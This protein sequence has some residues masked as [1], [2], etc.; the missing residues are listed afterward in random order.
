M[1]KIRRNL[2]KLI[3]CMMA[4]LMVF[5]GLAI[6]PADAASP[7]VVA[8]G[9]MKDW[10]LYDD[11]TLYATSKFTHV[12]NGEGKQTA[13]MNAKVKKIV[14]DSSVT[15]IKG[16]TD[17]VN[18]ETIQI[19]GKPVKVDEQAFWGCK[20]LEEI[21]LPNTI[22]EIG[23]S[24]FYQCDNLEDVTLP[25]NLRKIGAWAFA[26]CPELEKIAFPASLKT[27]EK[28]AFMNDDALKEIRFY[29]VPITIDRTAFFGVKA[30]GYCPMSGGAIFNV[31]DTAYTTVMG[32][33]KWKKASS[34][35]R[36][37]GST[38]YQTALEI[39]DAYKVDSKQSKF[40]SIIVACGTNFPDA[41]AASCLAAKTKAPVIVL[42]P[43]NLAD[44]QNYIKKNVRQNGTVY[45]LGGPTIVS[46]SIKNGMKSYKFKRLYD[47]DRYGTNVKVL[48]QAMVSSG[49]ILVCDGLTFQNALIAS[50]T[51]K[52]VLL[53]KKDKL[54]KEQRDYL[55]TL[56]NA[57]FTIIGDEESVTYAIETALKAYGKVS[58]IDGESPDEVSY[59]VANKYFK[60]PTEVTLAI[61]NN[62]P[63]GLCGG[64][65]A[66]AGKGP[67][68]LVNSNNYSDSLAYC[69]GITINRITVLGGPTLVEDE[70]AT[71]MMTVKNK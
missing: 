34:M 35:R 25:E 2:V 21:A 16:C 23:Q 44:V 37:Y 57:R 13:A 53:V 71:R 20:S 60:N 8:K 41:L 70:V 36:L 29:G 63:D 51:G 61:D 68:L 3:T 18:L 56:R 26:D 6:A 59:E 48:K 7:K 19:E 49:E 31:K 45:L 47:A 10:T 12:Y 1:S 64:P 40:N 4:T 11:G 5:T 9:T 58:R 65:L 38:R 28:Y 54:T 32:S 22:T 42:G 69:K 67:I 14:F 55:K 17:L 50:A 33:I 46:D 30:T 15:V 62:F 52:P 24:A 66:I 27:I 39:A 43:R